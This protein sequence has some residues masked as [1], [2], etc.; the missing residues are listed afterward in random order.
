MFG[1]GGK[2]ALPRTDT[3]PP[4]HARTLTFSQD[5]RCSGLLLCVTHPLNPT[6]T[7]TDAQRLN[8]GYCGRTQRRSTVQRV[9]D[10]RIA[11]GLEKCWIEMGSCQEPVRGIFLLNSIYANTFEQCPHF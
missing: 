5:L 6:K 4:E 1:E 8:W 11:S 7:F 3:A 2:L 10:R 9:K